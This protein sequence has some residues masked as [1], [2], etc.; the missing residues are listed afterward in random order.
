MTFDF[1]GQTVVVTGAASGIGAVIARHFADAGAHLVLS[2]VDGERL[3]RVAEEIAATGRDRP[4][5]KAGDLSQEVTAGRVIKA[6]IDKF[7]TLDVLVNNAGGGII[8][9]FLDHTPDTLRTTID[10][11][12]WTTLWCTWHAVP[13]MKARGYGRIVNVAS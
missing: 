13:V 2:D 9:P 10:R 7:G 6:A 5:V 12:L 11:N 4:I 8:K 1:N 3:G